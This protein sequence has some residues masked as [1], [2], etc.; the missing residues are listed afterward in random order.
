MKNIILNQEFQNLCQ[1]K[2]YKE[3]P[4]LFNNELSVIDLLVISENKINIIDYKTGQQDSEHIYQIQKYQKA[5]KALFPK[6]N[7]VGYLCYVD[8]KSSFIFKI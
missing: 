4:I 7:V 3:K 1:G 6:F 8:T 5:L 2:I